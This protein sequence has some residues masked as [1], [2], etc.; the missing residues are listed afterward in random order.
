MKSMVLRILNNLKPREIKFKNTILPAKHLRFC[1]EEFRDNNKFLNSAIYEAERLIE[2]FGMDS[3]C[4]LLDV[5]CGPGRLAIGILN[6]IE[7]IHLYQG[8]DVD[9]RSIE[10]CNNHISRY[11]PNFKFSLLNVYNSRYNPGGIKID[12]G[13]QFPFE[14][15]KFDIIYLYSV[16]SHM[17]TE[18]IKVYLKESFRIL[19]QPGSMFLTAFVE[20]DVPEMT[21]NPP[22]YRRKQWKGELHCVRFNKDYF[23]SLLES[24]GFKIAHFDYERETHGQSAYYLSKL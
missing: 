20:N 24:N 11:H 3:N 5:G 8:V 13:F 2:H 9:K 19:K 15:Q 22:N 17:V 12:N 7:D 4:S 21:I 6:R 23:E 18:D 14:D 1:G 16:F 10:W